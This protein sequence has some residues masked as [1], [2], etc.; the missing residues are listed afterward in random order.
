MDMPRLS[1]S[2]RRVVVLTPDGAGTVA[3]VVVYKR[4]RKKKK[5]TRG[6]RPIERLARMTAKAS[7]A[8]T[9]TY[10]RR[11]KKSNRKHRD[12]WIRDVQ[13]NTFKAGNKGLKKLRPARL[14]F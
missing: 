6:F 2:V 5:M 7:D 8:V 3:S 10:L 14:S 11:H 4:G 1:K 9:G 12:G 13:K